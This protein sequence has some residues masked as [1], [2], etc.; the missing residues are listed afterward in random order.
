GARE[1]DATTREEA[2]WLM[3]DQLPFHFRDP[4]DP[5]IDEMRAEMAEMIF[6]PDVLR[7]SARSDYGGIEL[8][9]RLAGVT[10]PVLVLAGRYDRTCSV[11]GAEAIAHGV[12][13]GELVVFE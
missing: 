1:A 6:A 10:Q 2:R 13:D 11:A 5:R 12:P 3:S 8:E 7:E 4:R 9:D